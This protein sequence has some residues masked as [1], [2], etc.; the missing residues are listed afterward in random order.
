MPRM[1]EELSAIQVRRL[2]APGLHAVGGVTGLYLQV[3]PSGARSWILR[4]ATGAVRTSS[5]GKPFTARR[6]IGIGGYPDVPL[7]QARER[8]RELREQIRQGV[9]PVAERQ[10]ARARLKAA[11]QR[12]SFEDATRSFLKFKLREFRNAKHAKQW[13]ATLETYAWPIIG[14]LPV[15]DIELHHIVT[16]LEPHWLT[17]TETMKR[18]RGRI[19]AVLSWATVAGHRAGDNPA[20]WR[21]NLD[22]VLPK[23]GKVSIVAHHKALPIDQVPIFHAALSRREGVAARALQFLMLTA[24][25]SGEVRFAAWSEIDRD[26]K[27]WTI[28]A[29]RMKAGREHRVP[30]S[31][32][33]IELLLALPRFEGTDLVF[34]TDG[35]RP[36]SDMSLSAVM[37]RMGLSAVPHGIRSTFRDWVEERTAYP[38]AVAEQALAHTI[39]NAVERA[40]RR[41]D[42]LAKRSRLM[43]DWATFCTTPGPAGDVVA[44][45]A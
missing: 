42:L 2:A 9:D 28:P 35:Q 45:R 36:L 37:R 11:Q 21:G 13:R 12:I 7:T 23:P 30:L 27:V 22:A 33:A 1:A 14:A 25:R 16:I 19:E 40:Y 41:G 10:T 5:T 3:K 15:E 8:A 20:R 6:D 44:I 17:R 32:A 34:T 38:H 31:D 39:G 43:A 29:S 4:Y 24:T 18:L 26:T